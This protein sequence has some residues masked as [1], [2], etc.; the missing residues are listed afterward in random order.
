[1]AWTHFTRRRH[2]RSCMLL[3]KRSIDRVRSL[4]LHSRA[5]SAVPQPLRTVFDVIFYLLIPHN[6]QGRMIAQALSDD[7]RLR[8]LKVAVAGMSARLQGRRKV[9][10]P[11]GCKRPLVL[12]EQEAFVVGMMEDQGRDAQ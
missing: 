2:D 3:R 5:A 8:I 6:H 10:R 11:P 12:N 9:S 1:M 4:N 7:L